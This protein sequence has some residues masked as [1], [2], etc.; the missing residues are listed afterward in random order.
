MITLGWD[1]DQLT[2]LLAAD[3]DF[4]AVLQS[5]TAWPAG[6][7]IALQLTTDQVPSPVVWS[8]TVSGTTA[9]F[10]VPKATVNAVLSGTL[11]TAKLTYTTPDIDVVWAVGRVAVLR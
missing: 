9:T 10:D 6:T 11:S 4:L 3:T 2:V 7:A 5:D 8:A 1:P